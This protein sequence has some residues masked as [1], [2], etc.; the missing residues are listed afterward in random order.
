MAA[1][2][3]EDRN[4]NLSKL[5]TSKR[6]GK[7]K[8]EKLPDLSNFLLSRYVMDEFSIR[9]CAGSLVWAKVSGHTDPPWPGVVSE[10]ISDVEI[11]PDPEE[12]QLGK[13]SFE[14]ENRNQASFFKEPFFSLFRMTLLY[15]EGS[16]QESLQSSFFRH[17]RLGH[18]SR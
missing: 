4:N 7:C 15:S 14:I 11:Q 17:R 18:H 10:V 1:L 16:L 6:G 2:P 9:F 8:R 12:P 13:R 3:I 5:E